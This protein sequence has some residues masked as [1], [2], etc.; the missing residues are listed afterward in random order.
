[1][2]PELDRQLK[3]LEATVADLDQ[4]SQQLEARMGLAKPA[5][6]VAGYLG[7]I[8]RSSPVGGAC[9]GGSGSMTKH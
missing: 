6:G 4:A 5:S 3:G 7:A 8:G 1:M 2:L 9:L